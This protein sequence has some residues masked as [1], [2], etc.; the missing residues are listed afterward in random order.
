MEL[1]KGEKLLGVFLQDNL[2]MAYG[3]VK[4]IYGLSLWCNHWVGG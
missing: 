3:Q 1:L 4:M 2:P